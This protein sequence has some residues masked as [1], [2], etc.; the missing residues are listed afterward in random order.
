MASLLGF[1]FLLPIRY[2]L[3]T[4]HSLQLNATFAELS[5]S[6]SPKQRW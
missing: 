2:W 5:G 6:S 1:R 4:I 3:L